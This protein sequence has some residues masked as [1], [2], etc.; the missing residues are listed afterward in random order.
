MTLSINKAV[1][2]VYD[3]VQLRKVFLVMGHWV[4]C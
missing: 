3:L 1:G 4:L 2:A